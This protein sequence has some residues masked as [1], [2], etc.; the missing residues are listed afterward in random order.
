MK[1][2]LF[3]FKKQNWFLCAPTKRQV[4]FL[5]RR[6][7]FAVRTSPQNRRFARPL[8]HVTVPSP[9]FPPEK[10]A[11]SPRHPLA[12]IHDGKQV[13]LTHMEKKRDRNKKHIRNRKTRW[14]QCES[15]RDREHNER[16]SRGVTAF[17]E[18]CGLV[19]SGCW[20]RQSDVTSHTARP[21]IDGR[22]RKVS[23]NSRDYFCSPTER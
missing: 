11:P 12:Q 16:G 4:S 6:S 2:L 20:A 10:V 13:F 23:D 14:W 19:Y 7:A 5:L 18:C 22:V 15:E 17:I 1:K 21:Q 9:S 3:K 8:T